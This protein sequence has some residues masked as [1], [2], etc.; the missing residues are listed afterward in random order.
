M[1]H[2]LRGLI[3]ATYTPMQADGS[4]DLV[5]VKPLTDRL[6][7]DGV[8]GLY[9]CGSTGE[10][11]SLEVAERQQML[12]AY[13]AAAA[14]RVPVIVQVG[15]DSIAESRRLAEHAGKVGATAISAMP[16]SYFPMADLSTL[17]DSMQ[18]I[19]AAASH[20]PFYYYHIP[21]L[22]G[23]DFDMA[24]FLERAGTH[25]SNLV[26]IKFTSYRLDQYQACLNVDGGR[27]DIAYGHDE[28]LLPALAVGARAA[29]GSTY[30]IAAPLYLRLIEAFQAG[31]LEV[32]RQAQSHAVLLIRTLAKYPFHSAVKSVLA[33]L[34]TPAGPT[35][36]PLARLNE[37][38]QRQLLDELR[39]IG[40]FDWGRTPPVL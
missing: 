12:E 16:P 15:H 20:L 35:R 26:G 21:V 19:A 14:G 4:L 33:H 30:N 9:V 32:A 27:F 34:G 5:A 22:A 24:T 31:D 6:L 25:I 40:F 23:A 3:A 8:S 38:Q 1:T 18:P 36:L 17:I 37:G 7:A 29:V 10:G 2:K 13:L 11:V 28:M 39:A